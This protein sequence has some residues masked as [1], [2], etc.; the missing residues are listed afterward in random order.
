MGSHGCHKPETVDRTPTHNTHLCSTVCS[1]A[2][3]RIARA[4]LK[5]CSVILVRLKRICHLVCT[6]LTLCCSLTC[7][8]PR[9]HH[10]LHSLSLLPRQQNT[11]HIWNTIISKNNQDIMNFSRL[12]QRHQESLWRGNLQ[13]GGNPRK[14]TPRETNTCHVPVTKGSYSQQKGCSCMGQSRLSFL[15]AFSETMPNDNTQKG[16]ALHEGVWSLIGCLSG[17]SPSLEAT[18]QITLFFLQ[19]CCVFVKRP[20]ALVFAVLKLVAGL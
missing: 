9:A 7:R 16:T 8:L 10:P 15:N 13:G 20:N 6:C 14:T 3:K 2:R 4:W 11:Q 18:C 12:K 17:I 19:T 5:N 1:Q